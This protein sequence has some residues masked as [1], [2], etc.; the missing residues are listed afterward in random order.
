MHSH[1]R[2]TILQYFCALL[3]SKR[4]DV[5]PDDDADIL[6]WIKSYGRRIGLPHLEERNDI[7]Q[8]ETR[9]E[10]RRARRAEWR[11]WRA[12]VLV[13]AQEPKPKSSPLQKRVDFFVKCCGLTIPGLP[14]RAAG[15]DFVQCR[16]Q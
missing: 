8:F 9:I 3:N 14:A 6:N 11:N 2:W 15:A 10:E 12:A 4:F 1:E 13:R 7:D 5:S 16:V